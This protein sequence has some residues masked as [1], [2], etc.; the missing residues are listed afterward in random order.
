MTIYLDTSLIVAALTEEARTMRV[1]IW[2]EAQD[3]AQLLIS[4]WTV[5]ETASALSLKL[6]SGQIDAPQRARG[7]A[8]FN[9][10]VAETF[11]VLA[12][13][14]AH[15]QAAANFV[16]RHELGLRA[17]DALHLAVAVDHGATLHTLD[18]RL[19]QAG[20]ALGA[21]TFLLA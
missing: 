8:I 14:R 5:T 21:P 19:A 11:G 16:N 6:R 7:L 18:R 1:Q 12:V 20:P 15:F 3:P 4:D 2:L 10:M 9:M 13:T 17:A